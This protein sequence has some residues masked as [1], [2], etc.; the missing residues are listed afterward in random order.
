MIHELNITDPE[1]ILLEG[2]LQRELDELPVEI[3]H[4]RTGAVTEEL[5][6]RREIVRGLLERLQ[7]APVRA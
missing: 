6:E 4:S 3:H 2:L 7:T 5:R 1:A